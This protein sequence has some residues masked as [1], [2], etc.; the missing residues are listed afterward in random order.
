VLLARPGRY[1]DRWVRRA[2]KPRPG[3]ISQAAVARVIDEHLA[4]E[5]GLSPMASN[6]HRA[7][8]DL[9]H[10][11]LSGKSLTADTLALFTQAFLISEADA[12]QL[13]SCFTG[14]SPDQVTTTVSRLAAPPDDAAAMRARQYETLLLHE[15][16]VIGP[17]RRPTRHHTR[18]TI[19]AVADG[20]TRCPVRF[21]NTEVRITPGVGAQCSEIY[22]CGGGLHAVDLILPTALRKGEDAM[23]SYTMHFSDPP[24]DNEYRRGAHPGIADVVIVVRFDRSHPPSD[25]WWA[26]WPDRWPGTAPIVEEPVKL[27]RDRPVV[28]KQLSS[29]ARTAVGFRWAW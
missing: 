21:D 13:W 23:F 25:V 5:Q 2:S 6:E 11:A 15:T 10:R 4:A 19:R 18:Q 29:A 20:V 12:R 8:K 24:M 22:A 3:E 28:R 1:R 16:H 14:T 27:N 26:I 9:V 7:L 17:D